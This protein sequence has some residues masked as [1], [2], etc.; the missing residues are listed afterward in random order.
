MLRTIIALPMLLYSFLTSASASASASASSTSLGSGLYHLTWVYGN[1]NN[2]KTIT[3]VVSDINR[4]GDDY[5]FVNRTDQQSN[6]EVYLYLNKN[7]DTIFYKHE[8]IEGGPTIGWADFTIDNGVLLIE[9]PTTKNFYDYT[10]GDDHE[11]I[12]Y[13]VG[14]KFLGQKSGKKRLE[15]IPFTIINK[16]SFKVDCVKYFKVNQKIDGNRPEND[17]MKDYSD[18][19]LLSNYGL[20]NVILNKYP[21]QNINGGWILFERIQ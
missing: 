19:V 3:G 10:S 8:E 12:K 2:Y 7:S 11:K 18:R 1:E 6:D 16:T 4:H 14:R 15:N 20:C 5:F 17:P 9:V 13:K 21:P